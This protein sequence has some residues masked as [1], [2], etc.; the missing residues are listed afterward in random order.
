MAARPV[1]GAGRLSAAFLAAPAAALLA[2][3]AVAAA[4]PARGD[5]RML[6]GL[7]L[8]FP[9]LAAAP[10]LALLAR[11]G[12]RAWLASGLVAAVSLAVWRLA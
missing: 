8:A 12:A 7:L 11:S 1:H 5:V 9:A 3:L 2:T 10:C 4:L 6:V